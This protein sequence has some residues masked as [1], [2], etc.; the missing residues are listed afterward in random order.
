M[1]SEGEEFDLNSIV[2]GSMARTRE[3]SAEAFEYL[4]SLCDDRLV[5]RLTPSQAKDIATELLEKMGLV[6][7]E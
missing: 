7:G 1:S 4:V 2:S 3:V 6:D 5:Q